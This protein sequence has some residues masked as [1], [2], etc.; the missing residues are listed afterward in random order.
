M[1]AL[2]IA[3]LIATSLLLSCALASETTHA[4]PEPPVEPAPSAQPASSAQ[5]K[6]NGQDAVGKSI[7]FGDAV[8]LAYDA[9][10]FPGATYDEAIPTPDSLLGQQHGS[11]LARHDEVLGAFRTW[12]AASDRMTLQTFGHTHEGRE[13]VLAVV[14]SPANHAR[15]DDIRG[16]IAKLADPRGLSAGDADRIVENAPAIAWMGYSIHGDELSGTDASMA[17]GYHLVASQDEDVTALL[18]DVVVLI[19][20]CLNPD[21]RERILG[22]VEQSAGYTPNLDYASMHRGHWPYGRGNH[23]LF[24]MNR[25]W[26]AGTQPETRGRWWVGL[27][28]NPQLFVDA[29]EMGSLDTFLFYPQA[30]PINPELAEKHVYWQSEFAGD[31]AKAFDAQGWSYYSR[32]W[33][34]GWGPFYSDAWGSLIGAI[35]IL[36]EQ[37]STAGFQ[38]RRA[39]GELLTYREAV[40]HQA[41]ASLANLHTLRERRQEI[42]TDYLANKRKNVA[43]DTEGNDQWLA[44]RYD[45]N[46]ARFSELMGVLAGHRIEYDFV[47]REIEMTDA[48]GS[49][50]ETLDSV[51]LPPWTLL[52]RARQPQRQLLRAYFEFDPRMEASMLKTERE[53]LERRNSSKMYDVT[54]WSL[55][56]AYDLDA[57]WGTL[58]GF[59]GTLIDF[60]SEPGTGG[61]DWM[62]SRPALDENGVAAD[63]VYAWVVDGSSDAAVVFAARAME[64]GLKL[65]ASDRDFQIGERSWP[66]GSLLLRRGE[67]EQDAAE[68]EARIVSAAEHAH[69]VVQRIGTGRS[70]GEGPDLGGGHF[71]LLARP[72]VA[73]LSNSPVSTSS[74]GHLW[75][76]LDVRLGVPFSILDAQGFSGA[77]LRRYNVLVLPP[78]GLSGILSDNKDDLDAWVRGGGTLIATA[79]SAHALT[80]GRVGLSSVTLRRHALEDL[81]VYERAVE[82]ERGARAIEI[83][84]ALVWDGASALAPE[85]A[86]AASEKDEA[87]DESKATEPDDDTPIEER[88]AW[89]RRFAPSGVNLLADVDSEHWLTAGCGEQLPVLFSGSSVMLTKSPVQTAVRFSSG[90]GLRLGGLLWPEARERIADSAYLT[91]ERRGNGQLILFADLPN[92]RGYNLG[93]GRL[94]SNAVIYGP[95][96][97]ANQPVGW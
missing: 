9:E 66:R 61:P 43:E 18:D 73:V 86:A 26:M 68:V 28:W 89:M 13:L 17:V 6:A 39:S 15:L 85:D 48:R 20:P 25:D 27:H 52:V 78:G 75:H 7:R 97:G 4:A 42:L 69:V 56:H 44:V 58:P 70:P 36:Y 55:P 64:L 91:R 93:T 65:H 19:D 74:Y 88:D 31:A 81:E 40:H 80:S 96:L 21:G 46:P 37:A 22:M 82:R 83:D 14:T 77:D 50:G 87:E 67:Q 33:A 49:R 92:F 45:G 79:S 94:F 59:E 62:A 8:E 30:E 57:W 41:T 76:H 63:A 84:E 34:D 60:T 71:Q 12:A 10:F 95:G 54:G 1:N 72:R 3:P 29:H 5:D 24:D 53:E 47:P 23:Y 90:P 2:R 51:T 38:L 11:R 35:G 16:Q 32:E